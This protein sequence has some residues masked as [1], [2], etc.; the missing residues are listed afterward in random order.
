[1]H[2]LTYIISS[3]ENVLFNNSK[4]RI[5]SQYDNTLVITYYKRIDNNT[6]AIYYNIVLC[7][8]DL[9]KIRPTIERPRV[10]E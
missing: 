9:K 5:I 3:V 4:I 2:I 8:R 6:L 1:M 7:R 10:L